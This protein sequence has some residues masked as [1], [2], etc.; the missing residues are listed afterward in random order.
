MPLGDMPS[1]PVACSGLP[2]FPIR[3]AMAEVP[4]ATAVNCLFRQGLMRS[5]DG[6]SEAT[7]V[8][9]CA[10]LSVPHLCLRDTGPYSSEL[11]A[12]LRLCRSSGTGD[13]PAV[14]TWPGSLRVRQMSWGRGSSHFQQGPG[15]C[16]ARAREPPSQVPALAQCHPWKGERPSANTPKPWFTALGV[17]PGGK[18]CRTFSFE[19]K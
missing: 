12:P 16:L 19:N 6:V 17:R 1:V 7:V 4:Q 2:E 9:T 13:C 14:Q 15:V 3:R 11:Q 10:A 8:C 5:L 18:R